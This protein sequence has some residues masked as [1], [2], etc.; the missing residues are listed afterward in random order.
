MFKSQL[1]YRIKSLI[2]VLT[3]TN[4]SAIIILQIKRRLH[5]YQDTQPPPIK[6]KGSYII[7]QVKRNEKNKQQGS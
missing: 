5:S 3:S 1:K 6:K 2:L 4:I 7:A